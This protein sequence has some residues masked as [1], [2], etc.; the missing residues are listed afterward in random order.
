MRALF[1]SNK[2]WFLNLIILF[3]AIGLSIIYFIFG[4][5]DL[6]FYLNWFS[7]GDFF[8]PFAYFPLLVFIFQIYLKINRKSLLN[9]SLSRLFMNF[10]LMEFVFIVIFFFIFLPLF[11]RGEAVM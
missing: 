10:I 8:I 5:W 6:L 11:Y 3:Y 2:L 7:Y 9:Y 1:L 4:N